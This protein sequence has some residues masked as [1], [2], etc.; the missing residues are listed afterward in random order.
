MNTDAWDGYAA[1]RAFI[2][3]QIAQN[4]IK[5]VSF[6]TGDI[7]TFFAGN[8]S[9][10]GR[11]AWVPFGGLRGAAPVA[12]ELVVGSISSQGISDRVGTILLDIRDQLEGQL[13]PG[14]VRPS[15]EMIN[16]GIAEAIDPL[17]LGLNPHMKFANTAYKGYGIAEVRSDKMKV[18]FR[19]T[20]DVRNP[21]AA[22][23]TLASFTVPRGQANVYRDAVSSSRRALPVDRSVKITQDQALKYMAEFA[24]HH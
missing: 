12:T 2:C 24:A 7:H 4:K 6:F 15:G 21:N 8:V 23:F 9:R 16:N 1:E 11:E 20:R 3:D 19:A 5:D 18:K 10:T 14:Y 22:C 17:A 13:N